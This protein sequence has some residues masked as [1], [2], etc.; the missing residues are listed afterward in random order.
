MWCF[1]THLTVAPSAAPAPKNTQNPWS[2][3]QGRGSVKRQHLKSESP[4][5]AG[6]SGCGANVETEVQ[7][8]TPPRSR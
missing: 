8:G 6:P 3:E 7:G 2:A 5:T 1:Q 4:R